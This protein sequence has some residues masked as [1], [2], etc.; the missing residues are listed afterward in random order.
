MRVPRNRWLPGACALIV[1]VLL[2]LLPNPK[3]AILHDAVKD[4]AWVEA[5]KNGG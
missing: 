3:D 1:L 2:F 4:K 5:R